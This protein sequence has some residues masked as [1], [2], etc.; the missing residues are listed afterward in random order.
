[1]LK[2]RV[3]VIRASSSEAT[4]LRT[5]ENRNENATENESEN[6]IR[7]RLRI[8]MTSHF[9]IEPRTNSKHSFLYSDSDKNECLIIHAP[10]H[11]FFSKMISISVTR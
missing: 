9:C 1:M 4:A 11:S 3:K 6:R 2:K 7:V 10:N 8:R 5:G